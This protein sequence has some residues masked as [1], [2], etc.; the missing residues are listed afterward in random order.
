MVAVADVVEPGVSG[1]LAG[2]NE[3]EMPTADNGTVPVNDTLPVSPIPPRLIVD[4]AEPPATTLAGTTGPAHMEKSESTI[5]VRTVVCVK[6][7][8]L[9]VI[10][11]W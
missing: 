8:L 7:P 4:V 6:D 2:A 1:T 10:V 9:P 11:I 5:T 3:I